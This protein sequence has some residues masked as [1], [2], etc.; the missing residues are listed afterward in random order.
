ML[1]INRVSPDETMTRYLLDIRKFPMLSAKEELSLALLLRGSEDTCARDKLVNSHLRL[2]AKMARGYLGYGLP[3]GD[4]I[5][6]GTIGLLQAVKKFD[7]D[8]GFRLSTYAIIWIRA[9]I[10]EYVLH[11]WSLVKIG[12]TVTQKKLFFNLRRLKSEIHAY[13]D[14]DMTDEQ[15]T[16][17]AHSLDVRECD[18]VEMNRRLTHNNSLNTKV[19]GEDGDAQSLDFLADDTVNQEQVLADQEERTARG[20]MIARALKTLNERERYIFISR[21]LSEEPATPEG[22]SKVYNISRERIRQI[23]VRA[24]EKVQLAILQ[25]TGGQ[26]QCP[27]QLAHVA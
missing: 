15:V 13:G 27:K 2:V 21:R 18:V 17:I 10:Q 8:R 25:E 5:A 19:G 7:P 26:T 20:E 16:K 23:E 6:E 24:F 14:G 9:T 4:L 1:I 11:Q 12:T 3:L 22:L